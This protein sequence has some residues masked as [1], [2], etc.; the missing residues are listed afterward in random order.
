MEQTCDGINQYRK[1]RLTKLTTRLA[2][3]QT[4]FDPTI[5]CL[6]RCAMGAFAPQ[7]SKTQRA[8]STIVRGVH[9]MRAQKYPQRCHLPHQ[10]S[11]ETTSVVCTR[12]IL[13]DQFAKSGRSIYRSL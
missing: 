10:S 2:Q 8:L 5:A 1:G 12:L 13:L 11:G 3:R 7:H 9:S 4:P 6:T